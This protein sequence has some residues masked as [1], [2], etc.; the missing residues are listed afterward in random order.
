MYMA[1][2]AYGASG[3]GPEED[4]GVPEVEQAEDLGASYAAG[5]GEFTGVGGAPLGGGPVVQSDIYPI[6]G[7]GEVGAAG[8]MGPGGS[9]T[10]AAGLNGEEQSDGEGTLDRMRHFL[11]DTV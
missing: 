2:E 3:R 5:G 8:D 6:E 4:E 7:P 11:D 9:T 10:A 1:D